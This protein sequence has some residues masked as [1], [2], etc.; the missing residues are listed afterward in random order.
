MP[1]QIKETESTGAMN[2]AGSGGVAGIGVGPQGEP[3]I[4][5]KKKLRSLL[6]KR[7]PLKMLRRSPLP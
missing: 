6:G 7:N 4:Y 5:P 3:G 2:A 1:K